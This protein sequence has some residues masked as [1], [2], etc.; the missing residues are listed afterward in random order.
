MIIV[1]VFWALINSP[2]SLRFMNF[3]DLKLAVLKL[4]DVNPRAGIA[5]T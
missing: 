2:D 1:T 3:I 4:A 5:I